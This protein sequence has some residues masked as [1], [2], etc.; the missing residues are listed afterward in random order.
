M[1]LTLK[2]IDIHNWQACIHLQL[3]ED[4]RS[5]LASNLYSLAEAYVQPACQP[6]GIYDGSLMI[7][8]AMYLYE[9]ADGLY[10]IPRF[11]IDQRQQGKGYGRSGMQAVV[12]EMIADRPD[13]PIMISI[14][15]VNTAA[16]ALYESLGF[17]DTERRSHG[18]SILQFTPG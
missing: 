13:T 10:W 6:R 11:M 17:E 18:E 16:R 8:F 14:T 3:A 12:D 9:A 2:T 4:Q 15:P 1:A 5:L 7:G